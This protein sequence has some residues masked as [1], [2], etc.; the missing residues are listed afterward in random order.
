[1]GFCGG[2]DFRRQRAKRPWGEQGDMGSCIY[3]KISA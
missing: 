2:F 1:M 3:E